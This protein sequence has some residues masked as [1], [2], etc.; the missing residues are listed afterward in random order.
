VVALRAHS[1]RQVCE[2]PN[3]ALR[4]RVLADWLIEQGDP[5]GEFI[6]LQFES[7]A[8][9]AARLRAAKLLRR[10]HEHFLGPLAPFVTARDDEAWELSFPNQG[11][12]AAGLQAVRRATTA[13]ATHACW[14]RPGFEQTSR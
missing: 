1:F 7:S 8:H 13:V 14:N 9:R 4:R 10:H 3:D 11:V 6:M 12:P 5:H 2:A